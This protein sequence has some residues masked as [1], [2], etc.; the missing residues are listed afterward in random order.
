[1]LK[2]EKF[3]YIE[4]PHQSRGAFDIQN[5]RGELVAR[6]EGISIKKRYISYNSLES[7]MNLQIWKRP[8]GKFLFL[9]GEN[10]FSNFQLV[11]W[12]TVNRLQLRTHTSELLFFNS[13]DFTKTY[14]IYRGKWNQI[15]QLSCSNWHSENVHLEVVENTYLTEIH[16]AIIALIYYRQYRFLS[17]FETKSV[18]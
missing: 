8:K 1:M 9:D 16:C 15:G 14:R 2:S 12:W 3:K 13:E 6:T 11:E 5:D 18:N 17:F 7:E 4:R 10:L